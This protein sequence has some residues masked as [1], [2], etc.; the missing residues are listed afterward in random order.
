LSVFIEFLVFLSLFFDI[1]TNRVLVTVFPGCPG[2]EVVSAELRSPKLFLDLGAPFE[3]LTGSKTFDHS[4]HLVY[5]RGGYG[6]DQEAD[7][8]LISTDLQKLDLVALFDIQDYI[9]EYLVNGFVKD[10]FP[11]LGR[12]YQVIDQ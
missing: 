10:H 3:D 7:M 8:V 5:T 2:K 1:I 9:F 4:H 6:L 11:V 12:E